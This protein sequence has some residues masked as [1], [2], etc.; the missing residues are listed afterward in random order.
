MKHKELPSQAYFEGVTSI[1][2]K[3][4]GGCNPNED[5]SRGENPKDKLRNIPDVVHG[6]D[7][8]TGMPDARETKKHQKP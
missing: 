3:G 6:C 2:P 1:G 8:F 4:T 5:L 7:P